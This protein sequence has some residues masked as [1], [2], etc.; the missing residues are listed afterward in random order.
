MNVKKNPTIIRIQA[1][2]TPMTFVFTVN[3]E[4]SWFRD[5]Q[6]ILV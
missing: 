2:V 4:L 6:Q 1:T 3:V 5:G